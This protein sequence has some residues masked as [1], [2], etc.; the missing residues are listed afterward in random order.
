MP[1]IDFS[2]EEKAILVRKLQVC[3]TAELKQDIG[4]FDAEFLLDFI[5]RELGSYY[6][7]HGLYDAQAAL[8]DKLDDIQDSIYQLEQPTDFTR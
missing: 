8:T 4:Q 5:S 7:N 3:C 6:Y 1:E 2:K